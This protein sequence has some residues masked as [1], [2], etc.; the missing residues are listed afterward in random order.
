M[1]GQALPAGFQMHVSKPIE[2]HCPPEGEVIRMPHAPQTSGRGSTAERRSF[3]PLRT[4]THCLRPTDVLRCVLTLGKEY[5]VSERIP[6]APVS[7]R[8]VLPPFRQ[9]TALPVVALLAMLL[10][11][12]EVLVDFATT[13]ELNVSILYG[14]P[15][16]LAAQ[17]RSRR[18]VWALVGMLLAA[19]FIVYWLQVPTGHFSFHD[20]YFVNRV[21]AAAALLTAAGLLHVW[22]NAV[23]V[24]AA[25]DRLLKE[26]N[27]ELKRGR[28]EAEA[29]STQK[30]QLLRAM[31]HDMRSPVHAIRLMAEVI[32]RTAEDPALT[33]DIPRLSRRLLA[34]AQSLA[35]FATNVLEVSAF[36]SG[37][38]VLRE[39]EFSLDDLLDEECLRLL[40]AAELKGL[41]L[42]W[43]GPRPPVALR[44]DRM[45]LMRVVGNLVSNAIKFTERG[46]VTVGAALTVTG[47]PEISVRDTGVG[48]DPGDL[49]RVFD[50]FAQLAGRGG[51]SEGWG[52]GL[53]ICQ[54]LVDLMGGTITV[55]SRPNVGTLFVVRLPAS[56]VT[57]PGGEGVRRSA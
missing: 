34:S 30:T 16:I 1:R 42:T 35:D 7:R 49:K 25:Q 26:Q 50:D 23:E 17:G 9:R 31:S 43:Q 2:P 21:L 29:R 12:A 4:C 8:T 56:C 40:P 24:V 48:I 15:L 28:Q 6:G 5:A 52:L 46:E 55:E 32:H 45:K 22:I 54:R 38:L 44:A 36:D 37:R 47:S 53:G 19:T 13:I 18:L 51:T 33:A 20:R 39:S 27:E 10:A 3:M 14:L 41:K 57:Q 11:A